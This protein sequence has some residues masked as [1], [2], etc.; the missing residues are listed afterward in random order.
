MIV[1]IANDNQL[2]TRNSFIRLFHVKQSLAMIVALK[3]Y[4]VELLL[5]DMYTNH[6]SIEV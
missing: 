3:F 4:G 2:Y 5:S 6:V 1:L